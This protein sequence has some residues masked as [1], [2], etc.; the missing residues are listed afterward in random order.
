MDSPNLASI[1]MEQAKNHDL[2]EMT[3]NTNNNPVPQY[4]VSR[5]DSH[6][7]VPKRNTRISEAV[8]ENLD[9]NISGYAIISY[10]VKAVFIIVSFVLAIVLN[11]VDADAGK[12]GAASQWAVIIFF[13]GLMIAVHCM[14]S[15]IF[16]ICKSIIVHY[17]DNIVTGET[18]NL[19]WAQ[20]YAYKMQTTSQYLIF[21]IVSAILFNI[22]SEYCNISLGFGITALRAIPT[23]NIWD[24][25]I[26]IRLVGFRAMLHCSVILFILI[27]VKKILIKYI[28][29]HYYFQSNG[30]ST[31]LTRIQNCESWINILRVANENENPQSQILFDN[32]ICSFLITKILLSNSNNNA[33]NVSKMHLSNNRARANTFGTRFQVTGIDDKKTDPNHRT[34]NK[35]LWYFN[36]KTKED[37]II[38]DGDLKIL[39]DAIA[40]STVQTVFDRKRM[41]DS[42]NDENRLMGIGGI[43]DDDYDIDNVSEASFDDDARILHTQMM[44]ATNFEDLELPTSQ[45]RNRIT[46][47]A[48]YHCFNDTTN[49]SN[50]SQII[51]AF[52]KVNINNTNNNRNIENADKAWN[53]FSFQN[54]KA[55]Y[56]TKSQIQRR[57]RRLIKDILWLKSTLQSFQSIITYLDIVFSTILGIVS[58]FLFL[59]IFGFDF[60]QIIACL[61]CLIVIGSFCMGGD[62]LSRLIDSIFFV[63]FINAFTVGDVIILKD[64]KK[65]LIKSIQ[66]LSTVME[67]EEGNVRTINNSHFM[68]YDGCTEDGI[69]NLTRSLNTAFRFEFAIDVSCYKRTTNQFIIDFREKLKKY[70]RK[71]F[72]GATN[73]DNIHLHIE[74]IDTGSNGT[75]NVG[76]KINLVVVIPST[77][78]PA[79]IKSREKHRTALLIIVQKI[80]E[81]L[82]NQPSCRSDSVCGRELS[83]STITMGRISE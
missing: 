61:G 63:L 79:D 42:C 49:M 81:Q 23:K 18:D 56:I 72:V 16:D 19:L 5:S 66:L 35:T 51:S 58:I 20:F 73:I 64:K 62:G 46:K 82:R 6:I 28:I 40:S 9:E 13:I 1:E 83:M 59:V 26:P 31:I 10:A 65:Y 53:Y 71:H 57:I 55:R 15:I 14:I 52:I 68:K 47:S 32:P 36:P 78:S 11:Q 45:H 70:L 34:I 44:D 3:A 77:I 29:V 27:F 76:G 8:Y 7:H 54:W 48:F 33:R 22:L 25:G 30:I 43:D 17:C 80:L 2:I 75:V 37:V 74:S 38:S 4:S 24:H 39:C 50:K 60:E 69:V 21:C 41:F 12:Y 67:D